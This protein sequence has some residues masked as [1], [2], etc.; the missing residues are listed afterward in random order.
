M[1]FSE[2]ILMRRTIA[3]SHGTSLVISGVIIDFIIQRDEPKDKKR[4]QDRKR[5]ILYIPRKEKY[6]YTHNKYLEKVADEMIQH[7]RIKGFRVRVW[8]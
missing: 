7:L 4:Q 6:I 3:E 5:G 1:E 2:K 8:V